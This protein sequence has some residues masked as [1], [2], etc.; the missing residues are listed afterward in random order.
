M[1]DSPASTTP[2]V[3]AQTGA[4]QTYTSFE[5]RS[6]FPFYVSWYLSQTRSFLICYA[7]PASVAN[8]SGPTVRNCVFVSS[9]PTEYIRQDPHITHTAPQTAL[10]SLRMPP[11]KVH[12]HRPTQ[13]CK[14]RPSIPNGIPLELSIPEYLPSTGAARC[15]RNV[16]G[17]YGEFREGECY[18][19]E[20]VDDDLLRDRVVN[21]AAEDCVAAEQA[22]EER[23]VVAL[24]ACGRGVLEYQHRGFVDEGKETQIASVLSRCFVYKVAF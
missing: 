10:H 19:C 20:N 1:G 6:F 23:V 14:H 3:G 8:P 5:Y 24:F 13:T 4:M 16:L 2:P 7:R 9:H 18:A 21:R 17:L 15:P 22:G 11:E 12:D